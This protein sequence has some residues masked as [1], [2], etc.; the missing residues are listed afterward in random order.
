MA[1]I[2]I[3]LTTNANQDLAL[4][5]LL[6]KVNA[7]RASQIPPLTAFPNITAMLTSLLGETVRGYLQEYRQEQKNLIVTAID[8]ATNAQIQSAASA[9]GVTLP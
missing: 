8:S 6:V 4:A 9:L 2:N 3:S 1:T 7:D 5:R